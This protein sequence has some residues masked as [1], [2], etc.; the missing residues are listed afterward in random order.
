MSL[1]AE[2]GGVRHPKLGH[3]FWHERMLRLTAKHEVDDVPAEASTRG[4]RA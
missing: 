1:W 4:I 3:V 2:I